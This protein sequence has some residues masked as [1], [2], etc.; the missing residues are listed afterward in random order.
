MGCCIV[1][2]VKKSSVHNSRSGENGRPCSAPDSKVSSSDEA[3]S[4][5]VAERG[6]CEGDSLVRFSGSLEVRKV[7]RLQV[8]PIQRNGSNGSDEGEDTERG[9]RS[10]SAGFGSN[11]RALPLA[12]IVNRSLSP[13]RSGRHHRMVVSMLVDDI[14]FRLGR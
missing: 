7:S 12:N 1:E 4:G 11:L 8:I 2:Q 13:S 5:P 3:L 9:S 10:L 14:E 6:I